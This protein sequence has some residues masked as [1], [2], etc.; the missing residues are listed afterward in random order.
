MS[1]EMREYYDK[2]TPFGGSFAI[3][4]YTDFDEEHYFPART[5]FL[6][7]YAYG[8]EHDDFNFIGSEA[9]PYQP[10]YPAELVE[11]TIQ[12]YFLFDT[13]ELRAAG[14]YRAV[15]GVYHT[16]EGY[17]GGYYPPVIIAARQ[18][19]DLLE[20]DFEQYG[21]LYTSGNGFMLERSNTLTL[22]LESNG[23]WKYIANK[24][25]YQLQQ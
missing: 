6:F 10:D 19:G 1:D 16:G 2:Y 25:T 4:M 3:P 17:G 22:R 18:N 5:D 21:D 20:L 24:V 8:L 11:S 13:A 9:D 15:N 14:D 23:G 12:N 7:S